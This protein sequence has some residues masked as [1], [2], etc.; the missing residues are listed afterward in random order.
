M[1]T[2]S[3]CGYEV[4]KYD[5][6]SSHMVRCDIFLGFEQFYIASAYYIGFPGFSNL[7]EA[8]GCSERH[9]NKGI[10]G[11]TFRICRRQ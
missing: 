8:G 11:S 3:C 9:N 5:V 2:Y 4:V 6:A 1:P 10:D 7:T